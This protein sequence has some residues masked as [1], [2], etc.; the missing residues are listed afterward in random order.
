MSEND[1]FHSLRKVSHFSLGR[2][3]FVGKRLVGHGDEPLVGKG[4]FFGEG[5]K[6]GK[7]KFTLKCSRNP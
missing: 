1:S 3:G 5:W 7:S 2:V 4:F 6:V